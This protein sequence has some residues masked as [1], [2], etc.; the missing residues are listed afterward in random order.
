[1]FSLTFSKFSLVLSRFFCGRLGQL[2]RADK[3]F[4]LA[5]YDWYTTPRSARPD[6][7]HTE[8]PGTELRL[9]HGWGGR[10]EGPADDTLFSSTRHP[11]PPYLWDIRYPPFDQEQWTPAMVENFASRWSILNPL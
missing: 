9:L 6:P 1:M 7:L 11:S 5:E 8:R 3:L 10:F 2:S 4:V